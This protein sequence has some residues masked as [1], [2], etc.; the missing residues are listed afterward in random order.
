[1]DFS[2]IAN[3]G[4]MYALGA[5]I[6]LFITCLSLAFLVQAFRAGRRRGIPAAVLWKVVRTSAVF[7]VV[8]SVA[9]LLGLVTMAGGLGVPLP[10][11]RLSVIGAVQYEL[12]AAD[13]A[14]RAAGLPELLLRYMT[15]DIFASIAIVMTVCILSGPLFN[16]F[17]LKRYLRN[18][19]TLQ[20]KDNRWGKLVVASLFMG[21]I[22]TFLGNPVLTLRTNPRAG[23]IAL[24]V[25]AVAAACYALC[26]F[27]V[28]SGNRK[29]L[30]GFALPIAM[31]AGMLVAG[32]VG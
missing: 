10:W 13:S 3:S 25:M 18:V 12:I 1:M 29:W 2:S 7:T 22:C 16:L 32:L 17:F 9:I 4:F 8:P 27:L 11:I 30:D 23:G 19:Q 24:L 20:E 28:R 15:P 21:M 5:A 31:I 26:D 6:S 14:A